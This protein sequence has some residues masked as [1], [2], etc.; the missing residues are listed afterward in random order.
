MKERPNESP[1]SNFNNRFYK[2]SLN[3]KFDVQVEKSTVFK[4]LKR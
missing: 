4:T 1:T 3:K 2:Q